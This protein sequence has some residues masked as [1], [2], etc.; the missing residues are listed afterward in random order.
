MACALACFSC[1]DTTAK[2]LNHYMDSLQ[3][4]WARYTSAFL[5]SL[6]FYN[7][8]SRPG[9][10][11]TNRPILQIGR[12]LLLFG[13]TFLNFIA[14]RFLQLDEALA[15][16]FS[17]PFLVAVLSGPILGEQIGWQR[18]AAIGVGFIGVLLVARPGAGGI[19]P[20]ALLSVAGAACYAVY[21]VTTRILSRTDSNETILF[22]SNFVGALALLPI[23]P[24][25]WTTPHE[26]LVIGLMVLIGAF[27]ALGHYFLIIAHRLAPASMLAPFIYGQLVWTV[28]LGYLVFR[29]VPNRWT[30]AGAAVVIASG[31]YM[32][33]R[34][35][36]IEPE[37]K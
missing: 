21:I 18:W 37:A 2:F 4:V 8:V 27:G 24:F 7:P 26:P 1:I 23:I 9:M 28:T 6:V 19:H 31:I 17:T 13:S 3:V 20:A 33:H 25:I 16:L 12:A 36:R 14:L 15:I 10:L 11:R 34:E 5:L 29:D 35:R 32:F 22:Y 30:L